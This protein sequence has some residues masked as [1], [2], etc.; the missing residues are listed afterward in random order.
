MEFDNAKEVWAQVKN[1]HARPASESLGQ[2]RSQAAELERAIRIRDRIEIGVAI[3]M[4]PVF[5]ALA[6]FA[7]NQ[8]SQLGAAVVAF[9]CLLIP[10]RLRL[11]REP[12]STDPTQPLALALAQE[13]TRVKAQQ[14]LLESVLWWYLAPLGVGVIL[15]LAGAFQQWI[16]RVLCAV[17]VVVSYGYLWRLNRNA[18]RI[19]L[20]P[21]ARELEQWL[22]S[23]ES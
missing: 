11:A 10:V 12:L 3:A 18:S 14:R 19:Q 8:L 2:V 17:V 23:L 15:F 22:T 13:L 9:G 5:G 4:F 16:P 7:S 20:A 1:P 6:V 21:R